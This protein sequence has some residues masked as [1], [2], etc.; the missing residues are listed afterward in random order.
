MESVIKIQPCK[1][2][3]TKIVFGKLGYKMVY[4]WIACNVILILTS[5]YYGTLTSIELPFESSVDPVTIP[6]LTDMSFYIFL[7]LGICGIVVINQ[8]L[9]IGPSTFAGLWEN[10]ALQSKTKRKIPVSEY[11]EQLRELEKKINSKKSYI[12]AATYILIGFGSPFIDFHRVPK[13]ELLIIAYCDIRVFL[14]S[15]IVLYTTYIIL[16]FLVVIILYKSVLLIHFLRKLHNTFNFQVRPLHP[17]KCGGLKPVG[18]F[19]VTLNYI[20]LIFFIIILI[21]YKLPHGDGLNLSLYFGFPLYMFF[22][23]F[24][25][26]YPLLPIHN[27]MKAQKYDFLDMLLEKLDSDYQE[28]RDEIIDR[29]IDTGSKIYEK[30]HK[31]PLWPI[32]GGGLIWLFAA[33]FVSVLSVTTIALNIGESIRLFAAVS[34]PVLYIFANV[35]LRGG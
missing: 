24:F 17:D 13:T 30:A 35:I 23:M 27:S 12:F 31:M 28:I 8:I 34:V 1:D 4:L 19:C 32:D 22:A 5:V 11:N 21:H 29:S 18:D 9:K 7:V 10:K 16:Y 15:G 33:V 25:F 26:F 14:L 3:V 20:V 2:P 6:L